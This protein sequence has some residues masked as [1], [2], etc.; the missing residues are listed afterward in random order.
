MLLLAAAVVALLRGSAAAPTPGKCSP[1]RW[2]LQ[3]PTRA[4][5]RMLTVQ[6][7]AAPLLASAT[8]RQSAPSLAQELRSHG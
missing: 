5:M 1:S 7:R 4:N 6:H 3:T 8:K 2:L